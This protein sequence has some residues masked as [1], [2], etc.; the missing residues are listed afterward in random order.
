MITND[1]SNISV[2][3]LRRAVELREQI[4]ALNAELSALLGG[5]PVASPPAIPAVAAPAPAAPKA[6]NKSRNMSAEARAAIAAAQKARWAAY[7]KNKPASST[8]KAEPTRKISA[9]GR[10]AIAAAVKA[11]WAK[12]KAQNRNSL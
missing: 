9:A 12:A 5:S 3:T 6:G 11:R 4:D 10:A 7:R 1:L 2:V 8:P